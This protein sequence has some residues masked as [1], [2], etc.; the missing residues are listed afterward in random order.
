M[1][2]GQGPALNFINHI[3]S[4]FAYIV[5]HITFPTVFSYTVLK[6]AGHIP[7]KR[8][9][10]KGPACLVIIPGFFTKLNG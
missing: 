5:E 1:V 4:P 2:R 7:F 9:M 10:W 6:V 3:H 8:V